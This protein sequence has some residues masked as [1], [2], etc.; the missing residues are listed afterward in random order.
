MY[1]KCHSNFRWTTWLVRSFPIELGIIW[2]TGWLPWEWNNFLNCGSQVDFIYIFFHFQ[3]VG[4]LLG[5][6]L[7]YRSCKWLQ[8]MLILC[9][10]LIFISILIVAFR[11]SCSVV[12]NVKHGLWFLLSVLQ[13]EFWVS[14]TVY[15]LLIYSDLERSL[16]LEKMTKELTYWNCLKSFSVKEPQAHL[17]LWVQLRP[18]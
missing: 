18:Y 14:W 12:Q 9:S 10:V 6:P 5:T 2:M 1:Q 8:V 13:K 7:F 17:Q 4:I 16:Y 3:T 11:K 15:S